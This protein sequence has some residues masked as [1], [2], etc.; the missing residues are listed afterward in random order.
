M[1]KEEDIVVSSTSSLADDL[2]PPPAASRKPKR[3]SLDDL[4]GDTRPQAVGVVDLPTAKEIRLDRI[5]ADAN[6]PR[7]TF[8]GDRLEELAESIRIEGV[9]QPVVV[10]YDKDADTYVVVHGERRWRAAQAAGLATI[11]ALVREVPEDRRLIQ[12]LMENIVRDDLNAVD[13][14]AALRSLRG[15]MG[16][17]PWEQVAATVGIKRSRL[18]QLLGTEKLPEDAQADIRAGRLSEKQSRALQGL[19]LAHQRALRDAI[20][21]DDLPAAKALAIARHLKADRIPDD[22][23]AAMAAIARFQSEEIPTPVAP[24]ATEVDAEL[25]SLLEQ[26]GQSSD[27]AARVALTRLADWNGFPSYDSERLLDE[28]FTL[29]Q[30]L[31]RAPKS[32]VTGPGESRATLLALRNALNGLLEGD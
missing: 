18:F 22:L 32:E 25:M 11:P 12:Q 24:F 20:L 10:R 21:A 27:Q 3:F 6:Q 16:D 7:R 26:I 15:Q 19:P 2:T 23:D 9:L 1:T 29:A 28:V 4:L 14:A 5:V 31:A 30:T 17:A 8:D 13:R